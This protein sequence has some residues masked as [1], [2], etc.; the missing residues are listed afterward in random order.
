MDNLCKGHL[1]PK[2]T[3]LLLYARSLW[4]QVA[5]VV[6]STDPSWRYSRKSLCGMDNRHH[7]VHG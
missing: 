4:T 1:S 5:Q 7:G 2:M 6:S 3:V